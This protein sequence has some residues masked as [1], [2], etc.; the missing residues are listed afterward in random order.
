MCW[1]ALIPAVISAVG[2]Y[3][4]S[5][6]A[7]GQAQYQAKV[8]ENNAQVA[9]WQA[10]DA[11]E[12]GDA[13][14]ADTRRKYAALEG[15]QAA[16]LA[17][18]GLDITEGSAN[19]ILTDTSFFGDMDQRTVRANAARE[20][21]GYKTKANNFAGDAAMFSSGADAINPALSGVLAGTS[22]Y[23]GNRGRTGLGGDRASTGTALTDST[24]V[25]SRWYGSGT[26]WNGSAG[27]AYTGNFG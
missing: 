27:T 16:S 19:A 24:G 14:A 26:N 20:A 13:A 21:W 18:R 11:K 15:T 9:E 2:A 1:V 7:K 3:Q 22:S 5:A 8:A 10:A 6:A 4:Q 17:A 12:R 25:S 23:F